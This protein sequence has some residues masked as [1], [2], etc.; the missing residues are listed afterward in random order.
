[1]SDGT[2]A[3]A[4]ELNTIL[5][6]S[7]PL[8]NLHVVRTG[9]TVYTVLSARNGTV[10]RHKVTLDPAE[11]TCDDWAFNLDDGEREVCA[12]YAIAMIEGE[13]VTTEDVAI[14][15]IV[16][17][18]NEARELA[19]D[20]RDSMDM[21]ELNRS[22]AATL[23][24]E[25][26]PGAEGGASQEAPSP[27]AREPDGQAAHEAAET[28]Q[29]AYDEAVDGMD[30]QAHAGKVWINKTPTA[31]DYTFQAFLQDPEQVDYLPP[32]ENDT[33]GQY[34]KNAIEPGDVQDYISEVLE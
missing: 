20:A 31:P 3:L 15:E 24:E 11:C 30:V 28:L 26:D 18:T 29:A 16:A 2:G 4:G 10:T 7:D 34:W 27:A 21:A 33:P 14:N 8:K 23:H 32:D 25:A 13:N 1:M 5:P 9:M 12:H 19:Q 17:L 22:A 6:G